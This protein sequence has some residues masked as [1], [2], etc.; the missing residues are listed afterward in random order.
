MG[1]KYFSPEELVQVFVMKT[2]MKL[3]NRFSSSQ[4]R[5]ESSRVEALMC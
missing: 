3:M 2:Q 4:M 1:C 5:Q